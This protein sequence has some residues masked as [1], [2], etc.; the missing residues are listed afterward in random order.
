MIPEMD[1]GVVME[2]ETVARSLT[3]IPCV[4]THAAAS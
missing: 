2:V 3:L 4:A 1:E